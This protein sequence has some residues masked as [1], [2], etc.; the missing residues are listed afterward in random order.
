MKKLLFA[1]ILFAGVTAGYSQGQVSLTTFFQ[2]NPSFGLIRNENNVL[3]EGSGYTAQLWGGLNSS[4]GTWTLFETATSFLTDANAGKLFGS[5]S[6]QVP[7]SPANNSTTF[8]YEVRAWKDSSGGSFDTAI[9]RG[10]SGASSVT[11]LGS[12]PTTVNTDNFNSFSLAVVPEPTT[13]VF[14]LMGAGALLMRRRK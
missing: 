10:S 11:L 12:P 9:I 2:S 4:P 13:V 1:A 6:S 7:G 5:G 8:F 14:G 3:I